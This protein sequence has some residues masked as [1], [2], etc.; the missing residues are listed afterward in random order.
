M[1][2]VIRSLSQSYLVTFPL[3]GPRYFLGVRHTPPMARRPY[4]QATHDDLLL[5]RRERLKRGLSIDEVAAAIGL[6]KQ[7]LQRMETGVRNINL[8]W[9]LKLADFYEVPVGLLVR[10]GDGLADEERELLDFLRGHPQDANI[11]MTTYRAMRD[12]RKGEAA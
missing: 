8:K 11:L 12:A 9:L 4:S 2:R 10:D 6:S 5:L 1:P 7:Q 3:S